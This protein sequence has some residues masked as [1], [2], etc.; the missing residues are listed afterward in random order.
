M[1]GLGF[2]FVAGSK[3]GGHKANP[4]RIN[5]RAIGNEGSK[6]AV[7]FGAGDFVRDGPARH[8]PIEPWRISREFGD[9][10]NPAD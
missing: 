8:V 10:Q 3:R 7:E 2:E 4:S 5:R 1:K 9:C 6:S